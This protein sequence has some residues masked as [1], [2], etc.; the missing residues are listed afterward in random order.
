ML[1]VRVAGRGPS[2]VAQLVTL[3]LV[4]MTGDVIRMVIGMPITMLEWTAEGGMV[5]HYKIMTI[6]VPQIRADQNDHTG[7][8]HYTMS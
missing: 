7:I 5:F 1:A 2:L 8:V 6:Q 3:L 4:Q